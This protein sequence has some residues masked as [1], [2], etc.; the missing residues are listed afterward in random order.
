MQLQLLFEVFVNYSIFQLSNVNSKVYH[1][2]SLFGLFPA[3]FVGV[4]VG[5]T[6]RCMQDVLENKHISSSTYLFVAL[7]VSISKI[8]KMYIPLYIKVFL[9]Q[10]NNFQERNVPLPLRAHECPYL[11][12][13]PHLSSLVS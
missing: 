5:S 8:I 7:Q 11:T 9:S 10:C 1:I 2:A 3:Q 12:V 6:L 13:W 4:Y